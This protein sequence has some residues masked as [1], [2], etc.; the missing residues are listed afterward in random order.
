M[1]G[2]SEKSVLTC[3]FCGQSD[4]IR[5]VTAIIAEGTTSSASR[6]SNVVL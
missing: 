4:Q 1:N 3:P 5:K 6:S 2:G